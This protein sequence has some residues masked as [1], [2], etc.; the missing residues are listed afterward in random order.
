MSPELVNHL[1]SVRDY[2][3]FG[4]SR[5]NEA[6]LYFGHGADNAWDD[7]LALVLHALHLGNEGREQILDAHLT[8][9]EG[10][11]VLALFV[12]RI[13]GR[14]PAPYLTG[15]AWFAGL[16]FS[17]DERV[18]I[19]RSPI[20]ELIE[21][22]FSPWL[23][24][25]PTAILDLCTGGG[26]IGIGC[27]YAF[28]DAEVVLSDISTDALAVA[29]Q[30]IAQH[31]VASRVSAVE[32]DLFQNI[33]QTFE[34]IVSNPPYVDAADYAAM[35]EEYHVEPAL[36]LESGAD[37][38]DFTRR[39]LREAASHLSEQ[40]VLVVEVGNS[41]VHLE[42]AFPDVPFTWLEFERGGYGVFVL[43]RAELLEHA[44]AFA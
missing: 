16:K 23:A 5:F 22:G 34:L 29:E 17:V 42:Q 31:K 8:P 43:T 13:S 30:N 14:I 40:G 44:G 37:G 26:C 20:A 38:L 1:H 41:A 28:P 36:A 35:P 19:P 11:A 10:R 4:T 2:I 27:A 33:D 25:E 7:A 21:S 39:L 32:S 6:K 12:R 18:L 15:T 24:E 9:G 3:R